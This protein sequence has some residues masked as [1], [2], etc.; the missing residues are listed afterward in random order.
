MIETCN[1]LDYAIVVLKDPIGK[2]LHY[3]LK[4]NVNDDLQAEPALLHYPLGKPLKVSVNTVEQTTHQS[5]YLKVYHDS[6]YYSSGGAYLD[7]LGRFTAIHLGA[8][9]DGNKVHIS[10]YALTL[11]KIVNYNPYSFLNYFANGWASQKQPFFAD[12]HVYYLPSYLRDFFIDEEAYQSQKILTRLLGQYID[13]NNP[14]YD[15]KISLNKNGV[16]V[17]SK[18]NLSYIEDKYPQ[19]F[20]DFKEECLDVVGVHK[21]TNQYS[22]TGHIESDHT[23]PYNVWHSTTNPTMQAL[24]QGPGKRP[25][26]KDMPAITI[27]YDTH[28]I[29]LTT[30]SSTEVKKFCASLVNLCNQNKVDKALIK[31]FQEYQAKNFDLKTHKKTI[32]D[33]IEEYVKLSVINSKQAKSIIKELKI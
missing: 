27:P 9:L 10:R 20:D 2:K 3:N 26:E 32:K 29:L 4:L 23:L 28:R 19:E 7:P 5:N 14:L 15:R 24:I 12:L 8:Q 13:P 6:D 25:G 31:C 33:S 18:K 22:V 11:K 30:G 1:P 21:M 16:V 17:F